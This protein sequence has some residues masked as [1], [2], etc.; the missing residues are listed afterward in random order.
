MRHVV[1]SLVSP[2]D[3]SSP[4][5]GGIPVGKR[6]KLC[7]SNHQRLTNLHTQKEWE[8]NY[9]KVCIFKK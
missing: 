7:P 6:L 9:D 5:R 1:I 8:V 4:D 3:V 2:C